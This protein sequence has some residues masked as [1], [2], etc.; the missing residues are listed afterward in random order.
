MRAKTDLLRKELI[1]GQISHNGYKI[2]RKSANGHL[3]GRIPKESEE[4][5]HL[6]ECLMLG[7]NYR[8]TTDSKVDAK[9][10]FYS[11]CAVFVLIR[12]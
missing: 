12:V 4:E 8:V 9:A 6:F 7:H 3:K 1:N 10:T 5:G 2:N 11:R